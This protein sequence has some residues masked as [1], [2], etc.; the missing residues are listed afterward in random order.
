MKIAL[1]VILFTLLM[2]G[3]I[4]ILAYV[5]GISKL[6]EDYLKE[7]EEL[8]DLVYNG[9]TTTDNFNLIM[10]R[11]ADIRRNKYADKE[12]LDVLQVTFYR[13]FCRL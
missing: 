4:G 12:K 1:F 6:E 11:L 10:G 3:F 8:H 9:D 2:S 5:I 13:R 7:Y